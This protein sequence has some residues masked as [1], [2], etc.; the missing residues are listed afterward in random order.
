MGLKRAVGIGPAPA[1]GQENRTMSMTVHARRLGAMLLA[2]VVALAANRVPA[3]T[4][5]VAEVNGQPISR[6]VFQIYYRMAQNEHV[7]KGNPINEAYMRDM[8]TRLIE[9]LVETELLLQDANRQG[10][11]ISD[12]VVDQ[13]VQDV[14]EG[15]GSERFNA[16]LQKKGLG[17][18]DYR[19]L[20]RRELTIEKLITTR[21]A[22]D[23]V[24]DE[25]EIQAFYR[26]HAERFRVPERLQIRHITL[27]FPPDAADDQKAQ[28][29][30]R[31]VAIQRQ[32]EDGGDFA[33]L[34]HK[35]SED[36]SRQQGGD[37][38]FKTAE[39]V[40]RTF[41]QAVIDLPDGRMS[42][43][44]ETPFGYHLVIVAAR[45]PAREI[46]LAKVKE[47]IRQN[48]YRQQTRKPIQ[49]YVKQ[50]REKA[51]IVIHE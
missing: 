50:L 16:E 33:E 36:P 20:R 46:P 3:A 23:V 11:A 1:T 43:P 41:G 13:A 21:I 22:P 31:I 39:E 30:E 35:H 34:A 12:E 37:A 15:T 19:L 49:A 7:Q 28:V 10:I 17:L 27:R 45:Q 14:R 40:R 2:V 42:P 25:A 26:R 8:R 47:G 48:L 4:D 51:R 29:R 5:I 6:Q 38:G 44:I 32:I 9:Y 24:V 18:E